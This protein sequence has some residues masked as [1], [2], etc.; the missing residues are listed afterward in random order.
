M[1]DS[2]VITDLTINNSVTFNQSLTGC[3]SLILN[4]ATYYSSQIL[5]DTLFG[6]SSTMCD[7]IVV[8]D[9]IINPTFTSQVDTT[10]DFGSVYT[11]GLNSYSE[12]GMYID[13]LMSNENCD[14]IVTTNLTVID[15]IEA[16]INDRLRVYPNPTKDNVLLIVENMNIPNL[17]Y[18]LYD[19]RGQLIENA[20]IS[21]AKTTLELSHLPPSIFILRV[22]EGSKTV[23]LIKVVK[24]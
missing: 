18:G 3:D 10:I 23:Q 24:Q 22:Y 12:S 15:G 19:L 21:K 11:V 2:I 13:T 14:S 6:Q 9:L 20:P 8:T 7:S 5:S 1:C 4:G 17:S 16:G